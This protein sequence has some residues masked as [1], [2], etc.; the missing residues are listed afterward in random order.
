MLAHLRNI[1]SLSSLS[2]TRKALKGG[3]VQKEYECIPHARRGS[4][5]L[6]S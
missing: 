4:K 5:S 6:A 2:D 1:N 3:D